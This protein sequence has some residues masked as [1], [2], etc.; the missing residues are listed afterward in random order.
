MDELVK[1]LIARELI[2]SLAN[3]SDDEQENE[4]PVLKNAVPLLTISYN[5]G[6]NGVG[7][8]LSGSKKMANMLGTTE[9]MDV[10][11]ARLKPVLE[12]SSRELGKLVAEKMGAEI[13]S[14]YKMSETEIKEVLHGKDKEHSSEEEPTLKE[15]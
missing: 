2:K 3:K 13:D 10:T 8:S 6:T 7:V 4:E 9:W 15:D 11:V 5:L 12:L 14:I 1:L